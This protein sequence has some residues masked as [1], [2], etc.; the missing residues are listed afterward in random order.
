MPKKILRHIDIF[1]KIPIHPVGL[2]S[3]KF[4]IGQPFEYYCDARYILNL[5]KY[6]EK[7]K[8]DYYIKHPQESFPLVNTIPLLNKNACIAEEAIFK[9]CGTARPTIIGGFSSVLMNISQ[10]VADKVMVLRYA[11]E[12]DAYY[13]ELG[14]KAGCKITY[15]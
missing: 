4:F 3:V 11:V 2:N 5:K 12:E 8:C 15:L 14:M 10:D 7:I 6:I 13:A 1:P 9:I